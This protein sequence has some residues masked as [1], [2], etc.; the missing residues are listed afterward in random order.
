[1]TTFNDIVKK[2]SDVCP[3]FN[4]SALRDFIS[5][6]IDNAQEFPALVIREGTKL[7]NGDIEYLNYQTVSPEERVRFEL[8]ERQNKIRR[9]RIPLTVSHMRLVKYRVRFEKEVV[10]IPLYIPYMYDNM[11]YTDGKYSIVRKVILEKTFSRVQTDD[12]DGVSISP[13]RVNIHFDR[14]KLFRIGS[15]VT[16]EARSHFIVTAGLWHGGIRHPM[17]APTIVLY[18]LAKFGFVKTLKKFGLSTK[19]ILFTESVGEDTDTF[20]YFAAKQ[21]DPKRGQEPD[22]FLKVKKT[23][24]LDDQALKFVVNLLYVNS[25]FD[26]PDMENVYAA[27]GYPWKMALGIVVLGDKTKA[28]QNAVSNLRSA[29]HFIDPPTQQRFNNFGVPIKDTYDVLVYVFANIDTF[30]VNYLSQDIYNSRFDVANGIFVEAWARKIF[31]NFYALGRRSVVRVEDVK[32]SLSLPPMLFKASKSG[33]NDDSKHYIA[34]PDIVGDNFL[35]A[36]GLGK[37]R[38]GGKAEQRFHPSF[39]VVESVNSFVGKVIGK[40]GYIN[41][42]VPTDDHGVIVHPEYAKK[43][44]DRIL[45]FLP[46]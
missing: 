45:D 18:M 1:M 10:V 8:Y 36:G 4:H 16:G 24:L 39:A 32:S 34:P 43:S 25:F 20:D 2:V 29:D 31:N 21:Y 28:Y 26:I 12:K 33:K 46:R 13:I 27:D 44:I 11:L 38:H 23:L 17:R 14:R 22:L 41:P 35:F 15:Y 40:Q 5:E 6:S 42:Y 3:D 7:V 30:M 9:P 19:D 37:I